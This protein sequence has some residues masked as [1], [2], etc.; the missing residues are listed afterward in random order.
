MKLQ[1]VA[2]VGGPGVIVE[3]DESKFGKRKYNKGHAVEGVWVV[4]GVARTE[5]RE[6][7]LEVVEERSTRTLTRILKK[8]I[9]PGSI[10]HTD[11]WKGYNTV[12]LAGF[13][14]QVF[15]TRMILSHNKSC[16]STT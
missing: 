6:I 15:N 4:G 11:C 7:F 2:T 16:I 9:L 13:D 12:A 5:G 14:C 10:V 3:V 8:H 1:Q